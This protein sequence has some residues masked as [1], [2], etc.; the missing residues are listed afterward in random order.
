MSAFVPLN[1]A[2][3]QSLIAAGPSG[4]PSVLTARLACIG[5]PQAVCIPSRPLAS[6]RLGAVVIAP[7][8]SGRACRQESPVVSCSTRISPSAAATRLRVERKWPARIP[9]SPAASFESKRQAALVSA[10]SEVWAHSPRP[11]SARE[12]CATAGPAVRP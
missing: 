5:S 3:V 1:L 12:A 11:P 8:R 10:Q 7:I 4:S 6:R 9:A 2:R